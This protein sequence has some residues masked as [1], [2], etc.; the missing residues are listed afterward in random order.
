MDND[1]LDGLSQNQTEK[2][3][4]FQDLIGID[5]IIACREILN[6]H[7]WDLE[8]A[9]QEQ[10]NL[11]EGRPSIYASSIDN[12]EP[13]VINDRYLQ[14]VFVNNRAPVPPHGF[15]G[16]IG[17]FF[18]YVFSFCYNT[19][20]SI[21][22]VLRDLVVRGNDRI[23]TDPLADVLNFIRDYNEKY[24]NHPVFYQGTYSQVL[25]DAKH[26]LKFLAVYLHSESSS[27]TANF[28]RNTLADPEVLEFINT[29][30]MLFWACDISTPEGYRVSHSISVRS[31]PAVTIIGVRE[32]KMVIMG[33]MEGH[34]SATEFVRRLQ[35]VVNDNKIWMTQERNE[36]FERKFVQDLRQQQDEA[37]ELSLRADQEKE[38]LKQLEK[39]RLLQQQLQ[40]E[41]ERLEKQRQ[42]E[43]IAR[44]KIDRALEV[45]A[46]PDS[47]DSDA[48]LL[49][50]ILPNGTR[51][52]RRFR[53]SDMLKDLHTY[54]FCHPQSPDQF[55]IAT[56]FP[57]RTLETES[58]E[59]QI[60]TAG[61]NN[62][63]V[64]YVY[65]LDA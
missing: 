52:E 13:Q 51:L 54:V 46:E 41:A 33:R 64:L 27:E 2:V 55:A 45:P 17:F 22:S 11:R 48:I 34:C 25:N 43:D 18:N 62:R 63:E 3:L 9:I 23:V 14:R 6:R 12:R 38:R 16:F 5:D 7:Q 50:F 56:N 30:G 1:G 20:S 40:E 4:Q 53:R 58:S 29:N 61:I 39:E 35:S 15:T 26:E 59:V 49:L 32:H 28:C 60:N 10:L 21:L 47:N 24:P 44:Q 36:R 31:C 19:L 8:V 37:Y 65:D 42:K 57:K